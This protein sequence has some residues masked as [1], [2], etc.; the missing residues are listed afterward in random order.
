MLPYCM[1]ID[2]FPLFVYPPL[3]IDFSLSIIASKIGRHL[4]P[5]LY[6]LRPGQSRHCVQPSIQRFSLS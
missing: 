1:D 2:N 3:L 5:R 6:E 4:S